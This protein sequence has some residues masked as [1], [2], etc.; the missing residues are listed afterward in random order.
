M[1]ER[2]KPLVTVA[3]LSYKN[4]E[5]IHDCLNSI[6]EQNYNPIQLI[7]S[8]DNTCEFNQKA[9]K[10]YIAQHNRGNVQEVFIHTMEKNVGTSK[11]FNFALAH[12]KGKYIKFIAADDLLYDVDSLSHLVSVAE[13]ESSM[14]VIARAANY[15]RYLERQE[16]IYPSDEHWTMMKGAASNPKEFFGI[17]SQFCLISA[18]STLY[19]REFL[20]REGGAN[21]KYRLIEDWPLWMKMLRTGKNFTF[22]NECT[23]IYRSGGVSN[24]ATN[25]SYAVHQIEYADVI[26]DECLKYPDA[27]ATQEQYAL[28]KKSEQ[29]HRFEGERLLNK[30]APLTKRLVLVLHYWNIYAKKAIKKLNESFWRVEK[31]KR[32]MLVGSILLLTVSLLTDSVSLLSFDSMTGVGA[33]IGAV[34]REAGVIGGWLGGAVAIFLYILSMPYKLY[35]TLHYSQRK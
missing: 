20:I 25:P 3:I 31:Y 30:E 17:M 29:L 28:A 32:N 21:E 22:L 1:A 26:R 23:A 12:S 34:L 18:P 33:N 27:M 4:L 9:I 16:W 13:S 24:G 19:N 6:L 35:C 2:R 8:D 15:D 14:V 10:D 7:V 11:N 5:Y